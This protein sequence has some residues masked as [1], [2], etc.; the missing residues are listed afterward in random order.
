WLDTRHD[1][2][3]KL[4]DVFG[5][6][7]TDGGLTFS[8]N[9][10]IT[11]QSFDAS[12]GALVA[13]AGENYIGDSMGLAIAGNA[14]YT[15]WTDTR[16]GN[17][18]IYFRRVSLNSLPAPPNDRFESNDSPSTA[19][20]LGSV[21]APR[22]VPRLALTPGDQDWFEVQALASA[23]LTIAVNS[24]LPAGT[25][26]ELYDSSGM[27]LL[28]GGVV[29]AGVETIAYD[30]TAGETYLVRVAADTGGAFT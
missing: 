18:D 17:Q 11:D 7:S 22:S 19:T 6:V 9:F 13:G 16:Q 15:A 23:K 12:Q 21:A 30:A 26:L 4:F 29:S 20:Q 3:N 8:P 24:S 1:P 14:M 28:A 25:N 10:R 2:A 27:Q 5:A